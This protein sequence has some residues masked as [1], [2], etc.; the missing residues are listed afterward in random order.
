MPPRFTMDTVVEL[1][2]RYSNL[3]SGPRESEGE[4]E[5]MPGGAERGPEDREGSDGGGSGSGAEGSGISG[6]CWKPLEASGTFWKA[7]GAERGP[8]DREGS[9]GGAGRTATSSEK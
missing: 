4:A 9:A 7:G 1:S 6:S 5:E 3:L 2:E 8:E